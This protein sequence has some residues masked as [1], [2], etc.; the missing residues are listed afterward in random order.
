MKMLKEALHSK[1]GWN[2]DSIFGGKTISR[3]N[4]A[5]SKFLI[6]HLLIICITYNGM[7]FKRFYGKLQ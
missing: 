6:I 2:P 1:Q 4:V 5:S 7:D 3:G